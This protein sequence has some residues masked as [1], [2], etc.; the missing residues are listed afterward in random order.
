MRVVPAALP[1]KSTLASCDDGN[2]F[3]TGTF[4]GENSNA[5]SRSPSGVFILRVR[6]P[7]SIPEMVM[8]PS[9]MVP[10]TSSSIETVP[11]ALSVTM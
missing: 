7:G 4:P 11:I 2:D 8:P 1:A 3:G 10:L 5:N 6:R 9:L